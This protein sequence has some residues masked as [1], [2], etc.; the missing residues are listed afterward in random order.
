MSENNFEEINYKFVETKQYINEKFKSLE[1]K[2]T[3]KNLEDIN[4]KIDN[5][6]ITLKKSLLKDIKSLDFAM[7]MIYDSFM[8]EN[9]DIAVLLQKHIKPD[10]EH[11]N[12][13]TN[14][15]NCRS[16]DE[17]IKKFNSILNKNMLFRIL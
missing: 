15:L 1:N 6:K 3:Q 11:I 12:F 14:L 7:D 17:L 16:F 4:R 5:L 13:K 8:E 2:F 9:K 10:F